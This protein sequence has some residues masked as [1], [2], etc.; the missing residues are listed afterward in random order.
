MHRPAPSPLAR[1]FP[2]RENCAD[3]FCAI[4]PGSW[5]PWL[6]GIYRATLRAGLDR[7]LPIVL[8]LLGLAILLLWF[9]N[10]R[11]CY[12]QPGFFTLAGFIVFFAAIS[13]DFFSRC[14]GC[15]LLV[16]L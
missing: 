13:N 9:A 15:R 6:H 8:G 4:L 1:G 16:F 7:A 10:E 2:R 11:G 3:A 5:R 12:R 14:L